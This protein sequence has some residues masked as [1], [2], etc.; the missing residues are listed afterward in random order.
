MLT[1]V[2]LGQN[3]NMKG[4]TDEERTTDEPSPDRGGYR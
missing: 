1:M 2:S 4:T 3:D